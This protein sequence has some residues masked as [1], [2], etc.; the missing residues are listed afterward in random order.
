MTQQKSIEHFSS[1]FLFPPPPR[2]NMWVLKIQLSSGPAGKLIFISS[3]AT[4]APAAGQPTKYCFLYRSCFSTLHHYKSQ[5]FTTYTQKVRTQTSRVSPH[6]SSHASFKKM[7]KCSDFYDLIPKGAR[8]HRGEK[9]KKDEG[10]MIRR[11][12]DGDGSNIG[13][14]KVKVSPAFN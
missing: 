7:M 4:T 3:A 6:P 10:V 5:T 9:A 13:M 1:L 14:E 12:G 8:W 11:K 2:C